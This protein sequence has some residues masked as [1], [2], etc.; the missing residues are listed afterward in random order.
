MTPFKDSL[1]TLRIVKWKR[2]V[3]LYLFVNF[4]LAI[5][6]AQNL[7]VPTSDKFYQ[8]VLDAAMRLSPASVSE[9]QDSPAPFGAHLSAKYNKS[10]AYRVT[11]VIYP[12]VVHVVHDQ[13]VKD[14]ESLVQKYG[15]AGAEDVNNTLKYLEVMED[16]IRN[17]APLTPMAYSSDENDTSLDSVKSYNDYI[18]ELGRG[19]NIPKWLNSPWIYTEAYL[20]R[21]IIQGFLITETLRTYDPYG[22]PK[23]T[24]FEGSVDSIVQLATYFLSDFNG[25]A[26]A[27]PENLRSKFVSLLKLGVWG[28]RRD[29][30]ITRGAG[31]AE[32]G[33]P[34]DLIDALDEKLLADDS[35]FVWDL[36]SSGARRANGT[37]KVD[38]ILDNAGYEFFTDLC[39]SVFI[40]RHNLADQV[41]F[42]VKTLPWLSSDVT[43]RDFHWT[44]DRMKNHENPALSEFGKIVEDYLKTGTFTIEE[45]SYWTSPFPYTEMPRRDAALYAKLAESSLII[46]KGD[47][48]YRKLL[49]DINWEYTTSFQ[50]ALQGFLPANLVILRVIK[51]DMCTGLKLDSANIVEKSF[52]KPQPFDDG[53]GL[54]QANFGA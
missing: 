51:A 22:G 34:L 38:I 2:F 45:E 20:Y 32:V 7:S 18:E 14:A 47:L 49:G 35:G 33:N 48:S 23:T 11:L 24:L 46:I 5:S 9:L 4:L 50:R 53:Y 44:I 21:R 27:S 26:T 6:V 41:R 54:I 36:I 43:T 8:D 19:K 1:K 42:Y 37:K 31:N 29:L 3:A 25:G 52:A 40:I 15:K 10:L 39:L 16:D 28:N 17:N 13:L 30:A 12:S